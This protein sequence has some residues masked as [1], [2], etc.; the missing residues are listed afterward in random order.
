MC[1]DDLYSCNPFPAGNSSSQFGAIICVVEV[2]IVRE[3]GLSLHL[4][5]VIYTL[6]HFVLLVC[7][8][9]FKM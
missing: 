4:L 3:I 5:N 7:A 2:V 1:G 6:L 8:D 9:K